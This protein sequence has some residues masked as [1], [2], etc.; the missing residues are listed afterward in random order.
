MM[1]KARRWPVSTAMLGAAVAAS[2]H[3]IISVALGLIASEVESKV[4]M[5]QEATIERYSGLVLLVFGL[6]YAFWAYRRHG[7]CVG[8]SHHGP[9]VPPRKKGP[10]LFLFS[11]GFSPCIA[12]LPVFAAAARMA[13]IHSAGNRSRYRSHWIFIA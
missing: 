10:F 11:V 5:K 1:T 12:A 7:H 2:G 3:I 8:H 9:E 13:G 6:A 4:L